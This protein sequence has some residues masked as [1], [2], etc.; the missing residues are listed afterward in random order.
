MAAGI[1]TKLGT[2]GPH[3][4]LTK[5]NETFYVDPKSK[6]AAQAHWDKKH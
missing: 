3:G 4:V 6:I 2:N 5:C 1:Y